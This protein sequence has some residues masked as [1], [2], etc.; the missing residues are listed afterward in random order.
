MGKL[1]GRAI[2]ITQSVYE[3]K[4][5]VM[6]YV[7]KDVEAADTQFIFS[8][9]NY[10]FSIGIREAFFEKDLEQGFLYENLF[11]HER[12]ERLKEEMR[13]IIQDWYDN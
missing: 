11:Q 9:P 7:L 5:D 10:T 13:R 4:E 1:D 3:G 12:K 8:I 6:L 2:D